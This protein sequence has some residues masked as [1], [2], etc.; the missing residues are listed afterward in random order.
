M[1][2]IRCVAALALLSLASQAPA[3]GA[4]KAQPMREV[5][6]DTVVPVRYDLTLAP[7]AEALTFRGDVKIAV[8]VR[9]AT[10]SVVLNAAGLK[11][12]HAAMD[13]GAEASV[14][15]DE[16]L[17]RATLR[18]DAP[19]APGRHELFIEYDG[20]IGRSTLGFFAMDYS[21]ADGP[22]RTLATNF[23]PA[24][25]R[26]LLPCWD[27]P[28]RKATFTL[29]VDAPK[30]RMA[31]S[32]M[33]IADVTSL[34]ATMQRVRFAT[35]PKMSTYLL[36]LAI[37]D[38]ERIHQP[39][40]GV[41]V[42]IVVKRGD[43][44]KAAYA[45]DQ[46][47]KLLHY[48]DEYFGIV[49]P[50]PKLDLIAA[51]GQIYGGSME[52]WGAIFY[53][54]NHLLFD[55]A[56]STEADRQLVFEVVSHEMAHQWFGDLVTMSWWTDLWLNE[57]FARWMQTY[58]A[59]DLHPEWETGLASASQ[60][61]RGKLADSV[62]STH[63]VVQPVYTADQAE[64]SFDAITYDKGAAVIGMINAYV[65]RDAFR[66]GVRRY[67]RVHAFGNTVD[68]DLWT[69]MQESVGKPIV[70]IER[71]FTRQEGLPLVRA[72]PAAD[73]VQL[74]EGRF[75]DDPATIEGLPPQRWRLPLA[76]APIGGTPRYIL[77]RGEMRLTGAAPLLI[78]AGQQG[79]ARVLYGADVFDGLARHYESLAPIDQ[80]GTLNDGFALG[81][82]GLAPASNVLVLASRLP[83][84][85]NP[86][87][88]GR[89]IELLDELDIRHADATQLA[90]FQRFGLDLL[91]PL[92]ARIGAAAGANEPSNVIILR[93]AL[94]QMQANLGDAAAIAAARRRF[95]SGE[96]T[97]AEQR[98]ALSIVA[99]HADAATFEA[100]LGR[101]QK[102]AD[103]L[104]KQHIFDALAG[105]ID[106][107]LAERMAE[108]ALTDQIPAGTGPRLLAILARRHAD[109]AWRIVAAR[110]DDPALPFDRSERWRLAIDIAGC[111][112][113]PRRIAELE[114]YEARSVPAE[115]RK[116]FLEASSSIHRNERLVTMVL[117]QIDRWIAARGAMK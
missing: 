8:D 54:Q 13:G 28:E 57:G 89:V 43:T 77:L 76:V 12:A 105:V 75:V 72:I 20:K 37:G 96:G 9:A 63:P 40:D 51:P 17:G 78:N 6:P 106:P 112:A 68:S 99:A 81:T 117:P 10:R 74:S 53:S 58:A 59:D 103:P 38:F 66:E 104:Q 36:F 23:E 33:P 116:P 95:A 31:V 29:S 83:A 39:V 97:A 4:D 24:E 86:I 3:A 115:A 109:L 50:L 56:A 11:F 26:R 61:E 19:I 94:A 87:V 60:L 71:D 67:M 100:L 22:R 52:N 35:S 84:D 79:Y 42:G 80:L 88:W 98:S 5:L 101:A 15:I 69:L 55:P 47:G 73:G 14:A 111:S 65:G 90:A 27:E 18:W 113:D 25:A 30:D 46:A 32:N 2:C 114:A 16:K 82:A 108:I 102:A 48:Y 64:E 110:L 70:A 49:F 1:P 41:D 34:S 107:A 93:G 62:P 85:A 21:S 92:A 44:A 45:L 91:M 7:D